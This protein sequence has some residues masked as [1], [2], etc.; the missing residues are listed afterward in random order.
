[1]ALAAIGIATAGL[2]LARFLYV[3]RPDLP[4]RIAAGAQ[5]LYRLLLNKYYV[6][7]LYDAL[8]VRPLVRFSDRVL[9]RGVDAGL[10]DG[11]GVNGLGR[12]VQ[13]FASLGLK[14]LQSGLTQ[15]YVFSMLVG[16]AAILWYLA[17]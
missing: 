3:S 16:A 10:I 7:E 8:I 1:M 6:D 5:G 14:H 13:A 12:S 15:S 4:V 9:Y 2:L 11:V 17:R